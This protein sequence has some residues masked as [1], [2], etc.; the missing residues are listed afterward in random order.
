[1]IFY[2]ILSFLVCNVNMT[3]YKVHFSRVR[4]HTNISKLSVAL[5]PSMVCMKSSESLTM[6]R[7]TLVSFALLWSLSCRSGGPIEITKEVFKNNEVK[8]FQY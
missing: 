7:A 6:S 4:E 2:L 5:G 3:P 8:P 1:M